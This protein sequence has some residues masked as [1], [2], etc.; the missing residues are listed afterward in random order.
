LSFRAEVPA[1]VYAVLYLGFSA[2]AGYLG[3][4]EHGHLA[5]ALFFWIAFSFIN[6]VCDQRPRVW[7]TGRQ[8]KVLRQFA[9]AQKSA[10]ATEG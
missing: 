5:R 8:F 9:A 3:A 7:L 1:V 6:L 10:A 2:V 4:H